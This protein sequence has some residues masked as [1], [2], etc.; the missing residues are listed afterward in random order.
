[1]PRAARPAPIPDPDWLALHDAVLEGRMRITPEMAQ[2]V[3]CRI[4]DQGHDQAAANTGWNRIVGYTQRKRLAEGF[5]ELQR[6][7]ASG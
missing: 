4:A 2:Y 5:A 7:V 3:E 6:I 1:M